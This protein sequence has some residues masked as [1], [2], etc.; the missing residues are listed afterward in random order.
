VGHPGLLQKGV[1]SGS[2]SRYLTLTKA[3]C[4]HEAGHCF[5]R[6][7]SGTDGITVPIEPRVTC[8]SN[9]EL[10]SITD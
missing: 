2:L 3:P 7:L 6:M 1:G 8:Q 5:L 10:R 4:V 9:A